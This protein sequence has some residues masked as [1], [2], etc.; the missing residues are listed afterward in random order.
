VFG[1]KSG[2]RFEPGP[3]DHTVIRVIHVNY[4]KDKKRPDVGCICQAVR[5]FVRYQSQTRTVVFVHVRDVLFLLRIVLQIF[6]RT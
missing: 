1:Q 2:R 4:T 5:T 6:M 3:A